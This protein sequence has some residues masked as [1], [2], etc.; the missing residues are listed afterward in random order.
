MTPA[1]NNTLHI[2]GLCDEMGIPH[3]GSKAIWT[4]KL[5]KRYTTQM[6][7]S[8]P[9]IMNALPSRWVPEVV[10]LDA[11]FLIQCS[12]LRQTMTIMDYAKLLFNRFVTLHYQAEVKQVHV[13]FDAPSQGK[14]N[15]KV[16]EQKRRDDSS[17]K[18]NHEHITFQPCTKV[19]KAWRTFI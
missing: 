8:T 7:E 15:S 18:S 19:P 2:H 1:V 12:P 11:M 5:E 9:V 3:K 13:L 10:I 16:Y 4:D 17:C 6:C 14:F